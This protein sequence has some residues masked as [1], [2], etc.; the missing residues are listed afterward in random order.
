MKIRFQFQDDLK[1]Q[2]PALALILERKKK[3]Y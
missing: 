1:H 2:S 3:V